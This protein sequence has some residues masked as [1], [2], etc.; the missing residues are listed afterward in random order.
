[1]KYT[2]YTRLGDLLK[3][4][5]NKQI[6]ERHIPGSTTHPQLH[7]ALHMSLQE[8]SHYPEANLSQDKLQQLLADLNRN[9]DS[10]PPSA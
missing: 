6:M 3:E 4:E 10:S 5:R 1:M 2:V 8:I 7:M 9:A